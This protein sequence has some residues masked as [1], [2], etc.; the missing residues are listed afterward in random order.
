MAEITPPLLPADSVT[1]GCVVAA[2]T[3]SVVVVGW[4]ESVAD[5]VEVVGWVVVG[6][7]VAGAEVVGGAVAGETTVVIG[8]SV[9]AGATVGLVGGLV[10]G[11]GVA[12]V[13]VGGAAAPVTCSVGAGFGRPWLT[14]P[15]DRFT[16]VVG[17]QCGEGRR[18]R[19]WVRQCD[20]DHEGL[21]LGRRCTVVLG[22]SDHVDGRTSTPI[23]HVH[24]GLLWQLNPV[25][26]SGSRMATSTL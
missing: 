8:A 19:L 9:G 18:S 23:A 26:P 11:V 17:L 3:A 12:A 15:G 20:G 2:A 21:V 10:E 14:D 22:V 25:Q 7:V 16:G 6:V 1:I 5:T 24:V 4:A 13:V